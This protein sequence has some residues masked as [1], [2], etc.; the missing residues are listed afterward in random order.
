MKTVRKVG[1]YLQS[2]HR[3]LKSLLTVVLLRF[4][5]HKYYVYVAKNTNRK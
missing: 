2:S 3:R 5:V 4:N 1:K